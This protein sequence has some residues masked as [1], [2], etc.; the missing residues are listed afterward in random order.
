MTS[1][2]NCTEVIPERHLCF[3]VTIH[4]FNPLAAASMSAPRQSSPLA[5]GLEMPCPILQ[6][7]S[8][9]SDCDAQL[10]AATPVSKMDPIQKESLEPEDEPCQPCSGPGSPEKPL[11]S[12]NPPFEHSE[13]VSDYMLKIREAIRKQGETP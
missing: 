8:D 5:D 4:S 2:L 3:Q 9:T 7:L 1:L 12:Q 13:A 6:S 10:D 11:K